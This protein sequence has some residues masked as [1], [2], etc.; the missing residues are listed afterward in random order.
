MD[1]SAYLT[2]YDGSSTSSRV[3][4]TLTV[5]SLCECRRMWTRL[6]P[7][8]NSHDAHIRAHVAYTVCSV[9]SGTVTSSRAC[10]LH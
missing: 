9:G 8:C 5:T 4:Y 1:S 3:I 6:S 10:E 2:F 7:R